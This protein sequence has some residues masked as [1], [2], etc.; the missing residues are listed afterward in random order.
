MAAA[1]VEA[2]FVADAIFLDMDNEITVGFPCFSREEQFVCLG[3]SNICAQ[4]NNLL[5][6]PQQV[7]RWW[8]VSRCFIQRFIW[9]AMLLLNVMMKAL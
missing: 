6:F 7:V 9:D 1:A 3:V 4:C 5:N 8:N 2:R